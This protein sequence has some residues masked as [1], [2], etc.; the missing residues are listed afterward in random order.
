MPKA[1]GIPPLLRLS[2]ALVP[3]VLTETITPSY[4]V[5][6]DRSV[7]LG[8]CTMHHLAKAKERQISW[9]SK[10]AQLGQ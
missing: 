2:S 8:P 6:G 4:P 1:A 3:P 5:A 9:A 7:C 10:D